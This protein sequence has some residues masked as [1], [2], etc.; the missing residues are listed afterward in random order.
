MSLRTP[1]KTDAVRDCCV[2][3]RRRDPHR[4]KAR[5]SLVCSPCT[6]RVKPVAGGTRQVLQ[7]SH[8]WWQV[9]EAIARPRRSNL[10]PALATTYSR[11]PSIAPHPPWGR[12]RAKAPAACWRFRLV[13]FQ[14]VIERPPAPLQLVLM[15]VS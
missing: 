13:I 4:A 7:S 9:A 8:F 11:S 10:L 14:R 3:G 12:A 1:L 2:E 6:S 15:L 5:V